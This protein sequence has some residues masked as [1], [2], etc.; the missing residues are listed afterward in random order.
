MAQKVK[1][2]LVDDL[3]GGNAD[4]TVRFGLD[5]VNYEVDLSSAHAAQLREAVQ[6]FAAVGRKSAGRVSKTRQQGAVNRSNEVAQIR[7]WARENGHTVSD[8]GRIQAEI[9]AAY[10]KA[11]D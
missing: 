8:R 10:H 6:P 1:I 9:V 3:D 4:E 7:A 11:N 2:I 5:G